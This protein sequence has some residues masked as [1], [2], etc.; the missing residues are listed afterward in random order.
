MTWD[1]DYS[2]YPLS[3][4]KQVFALL[5]RD[6]L[7]TP[8][9]IADRLRISFKKYQQTL[10]NYKQDWKHTHEFERGSKLS[11][12]HCVKWGLW[13]TVEAD[14]S[15]AVMRN[16]VLSRA[17]NRFLQF[18]NVLGRVVW[19]ETGTVRLHVRAP[20]NEGKAKQLFCDAFFKTELIGPEILEKCLGSLYLDS[21]HAVVDTK[22]RLPYVHVRDFAGTNGF[23][24]KS[25]DRTHPTCYEFI[26]HYQS[27][28]ER[29]RLLFE[30]VAK[31]L[32]GLGLS[33]QNGNGVG[34]DL[35]EDYAR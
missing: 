5:D 4:R 16:W 18:K 12:F 22:Q 6:P 2:S 17:K 24:F 7:L 34:K 9:D 30:D 1:N 31:S 35:K 32:S 25:A 11:S 20:G 27:Q 26:V 21:F 14:R 15:I 23:E 29:A 3:L 19:F 13:E 28:F 10:A 8:F 33:G